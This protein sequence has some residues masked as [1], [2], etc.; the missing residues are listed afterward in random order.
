MEELRQWL[1]EAEPVVVAGANHSFLH[2]EAGEL[3]AC[4]NNGDG[5]LGLGHSG[6]RNFSGKW[7]RVATPARV[8]AVVAG[9]EHSF[10]LLETG[11][12]YACGANSG[13]Q[14]GLGD[15]QNRNLWKRVPVPGVVRVVT[16]GWGCSFLSLENGE[17]YACGYNIYGQLGLG[18]NQNQNS[19]QRVPVPGLVG[20]VV[21]GSN[22]SFLHLETGEVYA[23]GS[24][25]H[26][27]LGL[28]DEQNRNSSCKWQRV[29]TPGCVRKVVAGGHHSFLQL[30]TGEVY[31][32][33]YN[34]YGQLGLGDNRSRNRW[35]LVATPGASP[36]VVGGRCH[37]LLQVASGK[38]YACG[39]N[40]SGQLGLG[41]TEDRNTGGNWQLTSPSF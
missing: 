40:S 23:S 24:N 5:Q 32:C 9:A 29:G 22:H 1:P 7:Q 20:T 39:A 38:V 21:V 14:L 18:H 28:G 19:W 30:E 37:S 35:N 11:E 8:R 26:G 6:K 2:L 34:Y 13:G 12:V 3:Y 31:A 17:V 27:Q 16:A 4:G 36:T 15:N 33:G 10:L 25:D 41:D